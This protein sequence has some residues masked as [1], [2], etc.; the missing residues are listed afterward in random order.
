MSNTIT[1]ELCAEDRARLDRLAAA[2]ERKA[3]DKCVE[4]ALA[5]M[6]ASK[7]APEPDPVTQQLADTLARAT[8]AAQPVQDAAG[9]AEDEA[10]TTTPQ[11]EE[12]PAAEAQPSEAAPDVPPVKLE[13]IRKRV[14]ALAASGN[15]PKVRTV[16]QGYGVTKVSDLPADKYAEVLDKLNALE[17]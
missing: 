7:Q 14:I 4:Q 8:E 2:L 17:G 5:A 11:E 13:D 1:L 15:T 9:A 12:T 10:L 6:A 16:M 3:C